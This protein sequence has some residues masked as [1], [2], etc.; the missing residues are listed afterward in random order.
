MEIPVLETVAED[1]GD[2]KKDF[3]E[4]TVVVPELLVLAEPLDDDVDDFKNDFVG[5]AEPVFVA[6]PV[7]EVVCVRKKDFVGV[8]LDFPEVDV[9]A[10]EVGVAKND[11]VGVPVVR[12]L[13]VDWADEEPVPVFV[14]EEDVV[15]VPDPVEELVLDAVRLGNTIMLEVPDSIAQ[16]LTEGV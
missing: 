11:F 12:P 4:V 14:A 8:T 15:G 6:D 13:F 7:D 3:V 16:P 2:F 1:V 5:V 10:E 9:V